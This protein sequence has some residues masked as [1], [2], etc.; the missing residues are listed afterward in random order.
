M[1]NNLGDIK[2]IPFV[3]ETLLLRNSLNLDVPLCSSSVINVIDKV[4]AGIVWV[5][6][7]LLAKIAAKKDT[8]PSYR[9]QSMLAVAEAAEKAAAEKARRL[10]SAAAV[11]PSAKADKG[12][13]S[14]EAEGEL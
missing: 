4:S 12:V 3:V 9:G 10:A 1:G 5:S 6:S 7:K 11:P 14:A 2:D 8:P 13:S